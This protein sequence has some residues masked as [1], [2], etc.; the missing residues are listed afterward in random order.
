[1][2]MRRILTEKNIVVVLFFM[3]IVVFFFAQQ[4]TR[5]MEEMYLKNAPSVASYLDIHASTIQE[6]L[7][8]IQMAVE[9]R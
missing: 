4:E 3:V 5:H 6:P 2:S 7:S 8:V 1:M 9:L